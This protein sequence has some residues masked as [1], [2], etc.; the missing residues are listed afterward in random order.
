MF[1][2]ERLELIIALFVITFTVS[3]SFRKPSICQFCCSIRRLH[4]D[5]INNEAIRLDDFKGAFNNDNSR[6]YLDSAATSQK[7]RV[8]LE[9][10][11]DS[12]V[13]YYGNVHRSSHLWGAESTHRYESARNTV[14]NFIGAKR[15]DEIVF[16]HGATESLN[17]IARGLD[18]MINRNDEIILSVAEHHSNIVPWQM[19]AN[20]TGA[21][22]R[23]IPLD[24]QLQLDVSSFEKLLNSKVKIVSVC[25]I[26]NVLGLRNPI[27][28]IIEKA[29]AYGALVVV[30]GCQSV[31]HMPINVSSMDCDF[32]V[33]SG[34]KVCGPTGIGVLYG[35]WNLLEN[36]PPCY[37]G[38][39]MIDS[40]NL[41]SSTYA[42][43]PLKFE[44]GT[45]PFVEAIGLG[46]ACEYL[47]SIG[48]TN[49]NQH[50]LHL[51]NYLL[52]ELQKVPDIRILG[53]MESRSS[54]VSFVHRRHHSGDL[55]FLLGK[56]VAIRDGY[57][58]AQPLFNYLQL[59][60]CIR[61]SPYFY[62]S[63]SDIDT[64]LH[65]LK[66]AISMLDKL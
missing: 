38:G 1:R 41:M 16:T 58:C 21:V 8:V 56:H 52:S 26:S 28:S 45:P 24:D 39:E 25:H 61:V 64:F 46:T 29:H 55:G 53:G 63:I 4:N 13:N 49:I 35:K 23:Y 42:S 50:C 65:H 31:P 20:R 12:Y 34:H 60:G 47:S 36:L 54:L 22:L 33:F 44:A 15:S 5:L 59:P 32:F 19:L 7:P 14:R 9:K 48:I 17:I 40:V 11:T 43:S 57:M 10:M 27:D 18:S 37:G 66:S 62:N 51:G 6:V 30:D 3:F 2:I